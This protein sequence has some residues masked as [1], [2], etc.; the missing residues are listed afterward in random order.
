MCFN[1]NG[2]RFE[3]VFYHSVLKTNVFQGKKWQIEISV[4]PPQH[5][6]E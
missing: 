5:L 2:G 3:A 1:H 6:G 4:S